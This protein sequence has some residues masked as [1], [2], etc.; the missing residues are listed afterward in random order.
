MEAKRGLAYTAGY[1]KIREQILT[2]GKELG[3][4]KGS[5]KSLLLVMAQQ[6]FMSETSSS[7]SHCLNQMFHQWPCSLLHDT[8]HDQ[9]VLPRFV[10]EKPQNILHWNKLVALMHA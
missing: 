4:K 3:D 7:V 8:W 10:W 6:G 9:R 5:N 2:E 1:G